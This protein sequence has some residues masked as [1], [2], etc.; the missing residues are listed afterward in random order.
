[1]FGTGH[2]IRNISHLKDFGSSQASN[3][4]S[5]HTIQSIAG[6]SRFSYGTRRGDLSNRGG[7]C[8]GI[9]FLG[10]SVFWLLSNFW[11]SAERFIAVS[12]IGSAHR[13]LAAIAC[14]VGGSAEHHLDRG[15]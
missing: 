2:W 7:F 5:L 8:L 3:D 6:Q 4:N 9:Y 11:T 15:F 13:S 1:V 14:A 12:F 10:I